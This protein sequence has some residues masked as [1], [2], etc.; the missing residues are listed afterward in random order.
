L[1][2]KVDIASM[3]FGLECRQPLLDYRLVERSAQIPA[4]FKLRGRGGK[5]I[6]KQAFA[7]VLPPEIRRRRKMGFGV[8]VENWFRGQLRDY[9]RDLLL[10]DRALSRGYFDHAAVRQLLDEHAAGK[11]N[12]G[13]RL[14]ALVVLEEW[15]RVWLDSSSRLAV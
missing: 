14:W 2:H 13:H 4:R 6:L 8:P 15:C 3:A 7:D 1:L 9:A 10:S 12:H 5:W 11:F